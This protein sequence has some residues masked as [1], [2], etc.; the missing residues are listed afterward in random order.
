MKK[1]ICL[2]A[3]VFCVVQ[4]TN[5]QDSNEVSSSRISTKEKYVKIGVCERTFNNSNLEYIG[6]MWG[7]ETQG[8]VE[9]QKN[10]TAELQ[11]SMAWKK[12][13]NDEKFHNWELAIIFDYHPAD[14]YLGI[15]PAFVSIEYD[16]K[17][18][19]NNI[20]S[21]KTYSENAI[22]FEGRIGY[23]IGKN[24]YA[25]VKYSM[26]N[27]HDGDERIDVGTAGVSIGMKF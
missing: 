23:L 27:I 9:I 22:G 14:F 12:I 4:G 2:L 11:G 15:G 20:A 26:V 13:S 19:N 24:F 21:W 16:T 7:F 5:A 10:L 1:V 6:V 17:V 25:E 18:V 8:G 3:I